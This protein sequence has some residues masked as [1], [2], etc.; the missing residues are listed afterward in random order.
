MYRPW[1]MVVTGL[2]TKGEPMTDSIAI[3]R[4]KLY[5]SRGLPSFANRAGENVYYAI[6]SK[7]DLLDL[8]Q[9]NTHERA[10]DTWIY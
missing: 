10:R 2:V 1:L 6:Y 5:N 9:S 7:R 4:C 3:S 8:V